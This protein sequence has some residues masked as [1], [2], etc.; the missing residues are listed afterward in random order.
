MKLQ[1]KHTPTIL[2]F[3]TMLFLG[4]CQAES[5]MSNMATCFLTVRPPFMPFAKWTVDS[6]NLKN[7]SIEIQSVLGIHTNTVRILSHGQFAKDWRGFVELHTNPKTSTRTDLWF[8]T[9]QPISF[10]R[11]TNYTLRMYLTDNILLTDDNEEGYMLAGQYISTF[12]NMKMITIDSEV[13]MSPD[14]LY[15]NWPVVLTSQRIETDWSRC[16]FPY[17]AKANEIVSK[18]YYFA[19][20][21]PDICVKWNRDNLLSQ[22]ELNDASSSIC[23]KWILQA[24]RGFFTNKLTE[25]NIRL[26]P[27]SNSV[28]VTTSREGFKI[29]ESCREMIDEHG[30]NIATNGIPI[31]FGFWE[32][33]GLGYPGNTNG[34]PITDMSNKCFRSPTKK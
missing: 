2:F 33:T 17:C 11:G 4:Y 24:N 9:N 30:R 34:N 14:I 7:I 12:K 18:L 15:T 10:Y 3:S 25:S 29:F 21:F 13:I 16:P 22:T 1:F 26:G 5:N 6:N 27:V 32:E 31:A 20:R 23:E 28:I 8:L 19:P